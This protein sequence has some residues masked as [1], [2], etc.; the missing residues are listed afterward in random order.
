MQR[1]RQGALIGLLTAAFVVALALTVQQQLQP[2]QWR[3]HWLLSPGLGAEGLPRVAHLAPGAESGASAL[4]PGDRLVRA[5]EQR[6]EG[7]G[8]WKVYAAFYATADTQ[9]RV[10]LEALRG[11]E[12]IL[13]T[14]SLVPL[15]HLWRDIVLAIA[16]AATA[17]LVLRRA[18]EARL[19]WS[20]A[21]AAL[22]WGL[23]QLQFYGPLPWQTYASLGLRAVTGFLWAPLMLLAAVQFPVGAWPRD[24]ALPRWPWAFAVLGLTWTSCWF[25]WPFS[26]ELGLFANPIVG[27][28]VIVSVLVVITRNYALAGP[29][30]RR[31]VR[32]LLLGCYV[33]LAPSLAG[34]VIGAFRPDLASVWFASQA[35]LIAIPLSIFI[36]ATRSNLLD[37]DRLISGTAS[38]TLLLV[39]F[40]VAALTA[41]PWVAEQASQRAGID[42]TVVQVAFAVVLALVI[43][44]L[45]PRLRPHLEQLFFAER[46]A[47][48]A[49]IDAL[50]AEVQRAPDATSTAELVAD[51]L[52]VL[53]RP[54]FCVIYA[55][56][57]AFAPIVVR[58]CPITPHF[59]ED[60]ELLRALS[61]RAAASDLE[62]D[63][64]LTARGD[65]RDRAA[66]EGLGAS[67][68][69][70]VVH[71]GELAAFLALGR[72]S[73]GDVYTPTDLA[74]LGMLGTSV[75]SSIRRFDDEQMLSEAHV[76]QDKL[77]QYV[78]ASIAEQLAEGGEVEA[79]ERSVTILFADLRGYT[80][81]SEGRQ[82]EEIFGI[83]NHYTETVTRAVKEHGGTVVEFNGDGMMA[84]FGAPKTL[85]D[86]ERRAL[87]AARR[88]VSEVSALGRGPANP[89][90]DV[91]VGVA[92]GTAYVGAIRS[93][94]RY[95]WSAIGN[96]TNLASR[97]Q[98]LTSEMGAP[99]IIDHETHHAA[100]GQAGDFEPRFETPIRGLQ[101]PR[102]VYVLPR[103]VVAA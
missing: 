89:E 47:L 33:G 22:V 59:D 32:W 103:P 10:D 80:S 36:A 28:A 60:S 40:G 13:S 77:R 19:S 12:R 44:R 57:T 61:E 86:K 46:Q 20:F 42:E 51:R 26:S 5:G 85:P 83:V 11:D 84:V 7:A 65:A 8:P 73:S 39:G 24:R 48:Q 96:T 9:G 68:L 58:R 71:D 64:A 82:A 50:V 1:R 88:I 2:G 100:G 31:Q 35:A 41:V 62:R 74:L 72:K 81:L 38:Y 101:T 4:E 34:T 14:E 55:L 99:I 30:G 52:D 98:S 63:R 49:G 37:I 67:V 43:V 76:L 25:A 6:L 92:T 21:F 54:E 90:L 69:V 102:D 97:L 53:L 94:D 15:S 91:G 79:G 56:G 78:P 3:S 75:A 23:A 29:A 93:V 17:L 95:I 70:P 66:L 45:E 27:S 16:F 87:A 18:P